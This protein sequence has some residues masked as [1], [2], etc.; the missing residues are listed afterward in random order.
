MKKITLIA[1][2][3]MS[4]AGAVSLCSCGKNSD[5]K[6]SSAVKK[7][8]YNITSASPRT[9]CP[10]DWEFNEEGVVL[11]Y[12]TSSLY[13]YVLNETKDGYDT[14]CEM[15]SDFPEDVTS[16]YA[17]KYN[18][19][20]DAKEGFAWKITLNKNILWDNGTQIDAS[21]VEYSIKQFLN[22]QMKN[23]R[24]S[25]FYAGTVPLVNGDKY[26][27]GECDWG[28]VGFIKNDDYSFTVVLAVESSRFMFI[29]NI[30]AI[31]LIREDL[32][33]ANKKE[34]GG[35]I[36]TSY[37]T[38][39][40]TSASY[41]PY[42]IASYQPDKSMLLERNENWYGWTDGKHEGQYQTTGIYLQYIVEHATVLNLFLQGKLDETALSAVDL[43]KFGNSEYRMI[44]PQ[45]YTWKFSFNIDK[46]SLKARN[47]AN[48]NHVAISNLN[49]RHALSLAMDRRKYCDTIGIGS[50]PMYGLINY[51]Y[52][53]DPENNIAYRDT[54]AAK[55]ILCEMYGT[56]S[57]EDITGYNQ[58]EAKQYFD[59]AYKELL[60]SG[61]IKENDKFIIDFH[62]YSTN[63]AYMKTV[64]FLQ[65]AVSEASRG[66]GFEN[67]IVINQLTD[68]DCSE[69]LK[70]G[71]ADL[72]MTSWGGAP[73]DPYGILWCY[74]TSEASNEYGFDPYSEKCTV[75][76]NGKNITKTYNE[77][78]LALCLNEYAAAPFDVRNTI[79][80]NCEKGLLSYYNMIPIRNYNTNS[81]LSQRIVEGS[82]HYINP[83]VGYGGIRY[84]SY[85][86]DDEEWNSYCAKNNNQLKY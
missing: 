67:K 85:T 47:S 18:I 54:D 27:N 84:R 46:E 29:N 58:D 34:T 16:E 10:T 35:L 31:T 14:I 68:Q 24:S 41:G 72:V 75:S 65:N 61:D 55:K 79:L 59:K 37:G 25:N 28:D 42:K 57:V 50:D 22:P 5:G 26:Y 32:Y 53:A 11:D 60:A 12:T 51:M 19:P 45:T 80:A 64:A 3:A 52:L 43:E 77:W 8:T 13:E 7:Y 49:F 66:T 4:F 17:G 70:K 74:C 38:S 23:Y 71:N 2:A 73:L 44:T 82:D 30:S 56:N 15:A 69:N 83:L 6:K 40:E 36:K 9:W 62:T 78:Y 48:E 81:M 1:L 33:E 20:S 86:M 21:T 39:L 76:I 63:D